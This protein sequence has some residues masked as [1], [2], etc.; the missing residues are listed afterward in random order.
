M[1]VCP[2][3]FKDFY[4]T[5]T[6]KYSLKQHIYTF[7]L[8][9]HRNNDGIPNLQPLPVPVHL[10]SNLQRR[11]LRRGRV[12]VDAIQVQP[13]VPCGRRGSAKVAKEQG[14]DMGRPPVEVHRRANL[15]EPRPIMLPPSRSR[16]RLPNKPRIRVQIRGPRAPRHVQHNQQRK[17]PA[18]PVERGAV[19]P[20]VPEHDAG[21][22]KGRELHN[23]EVV[24]NTL[25]RRALDDDN[26]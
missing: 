21:I 15:Q 24:Y 22:R 10:P 2:F 12:S 25:P 6:Q 3:F 26:A 19:G 5:F 20:S 4:P 17:G 11:V 7:Q 9:Q 16:L 18:E 8:L 23:S 14:N 13:A 1:C